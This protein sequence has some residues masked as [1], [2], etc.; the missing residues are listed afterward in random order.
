MII[1]VCFSLHPYPSLYYSV[2][3]IQG[4]NYSVTKSCSDHPLIYGI[5]E[6]IEASTG[7]SID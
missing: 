5:L 3:V 7:I 6:R 1:S 2:R 4:F